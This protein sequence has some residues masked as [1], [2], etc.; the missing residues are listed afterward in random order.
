MLNIAKRMDRINPN[1]ANF[2]QEEIRK[3]LDANPERDVDRRSEGFGRDAE[4]V[5]KASSLQSDK[6]ANFHNTKPHE[7]RAKNSGEFSTSA[8]SNANKLKQP[9]IMSS[10]TSSFKNIMNILNGSANNSSHGTDK[11]ITSSSKFDKSSHKCRDIQQIDQAI[12]DN[13]QQNSNH[14]TSGTSSNN[15]ASTDTKESLLQIV[16]LETPSSLGLQFHS[17]K[18]TSKIISYPDAPKGQIIRGGRS[19]LSRSNKR[20]T[21][22]HKNSEK[23]LSEYSNESSTSIP[24]GYFN[25]NASYKIICKRMNPQLAN[26]IGVSHCNS[27]VENSEHPI[28]VPPSIHGL[29]NSPRIIPNYYLTTNMKHGILSVDYHFIILDDIRNLRPLNPAQLKYI[30]EKLSNE[31]KQAIIVEFNDV[32]N[33]FCNILHELDE[34]PERDIVRRK[35][36]FRRDDENVLDTYP[37]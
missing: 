7:I 25:F 13:L 19:P 22:V 3:Q 34:N 33:S 29:E 21:S 11:N 20:N 4:N 6:F 28:Y 5:V 36:I 23:V 12:K 31:Q 26:M 8:N 37:K 27:S 15:G 9:S 17:P 10:I 1:N 24:S 16:P 18:K 35:E 14:A 30:E 2:Q 32:M